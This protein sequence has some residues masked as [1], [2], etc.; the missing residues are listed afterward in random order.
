AYTGSLAGRDPAL[1]TSDS[2]TGLVGDAPTAPPLS[3]PTGA[4][5]VGTTLTASRP[6]WNLA[7]VTEAVEWLRD[8]QTIAGETTSSYVVQPADAAA[9]VSVRVTGTLP[10]RT[11][12]T[13]T[14]PAVVGLLGDA[15]SAPTPA[16]PAGSGMVGTVLTSTAPAWNVTTEQQTTQ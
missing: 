1:V 2:V 6:A 11:P 9:S 4:R 5:K 8:G 14:S 16:A 12:G 10:G 3:A 13:V 7:G 15:P